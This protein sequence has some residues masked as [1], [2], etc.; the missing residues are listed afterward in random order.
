MSLPGYRIVNI[1]GLLGY[2]VGA[3]AMTVAQG[4]TAVIV[5]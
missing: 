1:L 5:F 3:L 2:A 4:L